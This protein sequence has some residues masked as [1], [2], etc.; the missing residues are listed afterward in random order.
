MNK[1]LADKYILPRCILSYL[2]YEELFRMKEN[3]I[4]VKYFDEI[5]VE[6]GIKYVDD[7]EKWTSIFPKAKKLRIGPKLTLDKMIIKSSYLTFLNADE[8]SVTD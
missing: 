6:D 8:C 4:F 2:N 1:I 7:L 3:N 5:P